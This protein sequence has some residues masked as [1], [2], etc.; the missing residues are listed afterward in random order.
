MFPLS[1]RLCFALLSVA[2]CLGARTAHAQANP[3]T[4]WTPGWPIGF[5][6][7]PTAGGA[8]TYGNFPGFDGS[9]AR[10]PGF[11]YKHY[12][13]SNWAG[14]GMGL[15]LSGINQYGAYGNIGSLSYEGMQFGYN[16]KNAPLSVYAGFDTLKYD[17]G[18]GGPFGAFDSTSTLP[19]Y[20][21]HAG[22]E[23]QPAP[24]VSLSLGVSYAGQQSGRVDSDINS[25]LPPGA[26]PFA[27]GARR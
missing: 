16:F 7:D 11:T 10:R 14:S 23:F 24:N 13:F 12:S 17:S 9:D 25:P 1:S 15:G 2:L 26:T 19:A 6:A 21:A 22:V 27:F 3:L 18:I 20:G 8:D 4:Y 5:G